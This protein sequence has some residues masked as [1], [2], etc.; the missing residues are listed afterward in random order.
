MKK[1]ILIFTV[2]I[3]TVTFAQNKNAKA[4]IEVDGVCGMCKER[5]EKAAIRTKG[6]KSAVWNVDTHELKL[7]FDERKTDVKTISKNIAAVGHDT[8]EIKATD[9][10]YHSVHACC[11][12]RDEDVKKDHEKKE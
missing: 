6:V 1:I 4:N 11:L 7:I 8:K 9:E 3:T 10:Q 12:Y 2:L 5:I